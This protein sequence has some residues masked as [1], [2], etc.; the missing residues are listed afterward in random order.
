MNKASFDV[1][2]EKLNLGFRRRI[3][4]ILQTEAAEC[5]LA[6]L[7]MVFHY[8]GLQIDLSSLRSQF[9]ISTRG[10]TL[11]V[12]IS[13]ATALKFKTRAVS[14]DLDEL[15]ALKTPCVLHWD[16]NHFV[17]LVSVKKN[18]ITIHDPAFGQRVMSTQEFSK[19]F[20]GIALE[21][22]PGNDFTPVKK[23]NRLRIIS[24][25]NNIQGIK[26]ALGKIFFLSV[27]IEAINILLPVGTQLVMDHV[28]V[29]QDH[30]LL[31]IICCG[32]LFFI[33]FRISVSTLRSWISITM[34]AFVDVQWK[35]G[36]FDHLMKLPLAYFEKRKLGDIQSRFGSLN[37]I[38]TT[39]TQ[40]IVNGIID[41]IMLISVFV[42]MLLYGNWLVWI[43][44][45]FT[46]IYIVVRFLTYQYYRQLSE[47][48]IVKEARANSHFMETLYS[49][50]TLKALGLCE[51]R[52]KSWLNLNIDTLNS[53]TK[54]NKISS[55]FNIINVFITTCEQIIILW[56]GASLVIDNQMTLGMFVAFNAYRGQFADRA[57]NLIDMAI[58]LRMLNLHNERI[59][60]IVLSEPEREAPAREIGVSGQPVDLTVHDL[61]YQYDSLSKPVISGFNLNVKAGESVA[62]IGPSGAGKTTLMKLMS[63]LL[64]P[65][66]GTILMNGLDINVIGLNNYRKC[67]ACVLQDDKL[68][69]GSIAE[70]I[71]GFDPSPDIELIQECA[72]RCSIHDDILLMPMGYETLIGELGNGLSGGQIQRLLIA[73]AL[74]RRPS[75]L[76]MDEATSHLDLTN[77]AYINESISA[78]NIT[79]IIIAHRPSTIKSAERVISIS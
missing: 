34:E 79:R 29:A 15:H 3:P 64:E 75:I 26:S 5:G 50:N 19:H 42:M 2:T 74:Y 43:V 20:T 21:L 58:K 46:I 18:K 17:V 52:A 35:S 36:V 41:T 56:L 67:I 53:N 39:F 72:K 51:T 47:E 31:T 11:P 57:S 33:L 12:L 65:D 30:N 32:L 14:L 25:L 59:A 27:V 76:F 45:G 6:S 8:H 28:I 60:D 38:R 61:H 69:S 66:K 4:K 73:R 13:I 9:G 71:S 37:I 62:I 23:Q 49:I 16:M 55:I 68:L 1:I 24:L 10:A 63:G 78:L 44:S 40:N 22:W 70:N 48:Q 54:L 7:A 77:E